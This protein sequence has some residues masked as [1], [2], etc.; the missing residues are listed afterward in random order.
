[1]MVWAVNGAAGFGKTFRLLQRTGEQLKASPLDAGQQVLA[2]TFMHGA[3]QRLDQKLR[4]MPDLRGRYQC[5]TVDGFARS[6]RWRWRSLARSIGQP[7]TDA[8]SFDEQCSLA[9]ELV[10]RPVVSNWLATGYPCV[11][12]DEGQDL[13]PHRLQLIEALALC[14]RVLIAYDDFQ[15]LKVE[16]RPSPV[17]VW[18]PSVCK[19]EELSK[20]RRCSVRALLDASSALRSGLAPVTGQGFKIAA[21]ASAAQ[22]AALL[23]SIIHFARI[24]TPKCSV[25]VITP[26]RKGGYADEVVEMVSSKPCGSKQLGPFK[27][28]WEVAESPLL[29]AVEKM[30]FDGVKPC[31][32]VV[33]EI[34][35]DA[36]DGAARDALV[37]WV[38]RQR[39]LAGR[40]AIN[41]S[42]LSG[43][44][45]RV[46][47]V[48]R[49]RANRTD[50][51]IR[52]LTVH[53]AKNREFDVVI[54]IWPYTVA[55]DDEGKRRLLYNAITRARLQCTVIVQGAASTGKP[56]FR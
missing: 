32:E 27:L 44:A 5:L 26:A 16:L 47:A 48:T 24:K 45:R 12:L 49:A 29:E 15:C 41:F 34:L 36:D 51:G 43:Q 40:A 9:A 38:L 33:H 17:S 20:P 25:A 11:L 54:A 22:A 37:R 1:M 53:Q 8:V 35:A 42:E 50:S 46:I 6:L 13:D 31:S 30:A 14:S 3:R 56:P 2:L 4:G 21:C 19:P 10:R 18:L 28:R 39:D 52:A 55:Q 7:N 23:A